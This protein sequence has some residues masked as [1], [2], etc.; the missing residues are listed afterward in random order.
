MFGINTKMSKANH[1]GGWG[2]VNGKQCENTQQKK[3]QKS[4]KLNETE[5]SEDLYIGYIEQEKQRV[6]GVIS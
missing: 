2:E 6:D 4:H 5:K 1:F 3:T